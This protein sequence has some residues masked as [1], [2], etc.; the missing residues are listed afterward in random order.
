M[1]GLH[2]AM[3]EAAEEDVPGIEITTDAQE[4]ERQGIVMSSLFPY[5]LYVEHFGI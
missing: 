5:T 4:A 3:E 1:N 2:H